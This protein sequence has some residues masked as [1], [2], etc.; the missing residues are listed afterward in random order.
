MTIIKRSLIYLLFL[1]I[2]ILI[3]LSFKKLNLFNNTDA[4][5]TR[6]MLS[7]LVQGEFTVIVLILTMSLIVVQLV[8]QSYSIR[9]IDLFRE[10]P[11]FWALILVYGFAIF[12]GLYVLGMIGSSNINDIEAYISGLYY[13]GIFVYVILIPY[14]WQILDLLKPYTVIK[15]LAERMNQNDLAESKEDNKI[16]KMND[17]TVPIIDIINNSLIRQDLETFEISLTTLSGHIKKTFEKENYNKEKISIRILNHITDI[18]K[19]AANQKNEPFTIIIIDH[20]VKIG[21]I[22]IRQ[23][24]D[25]SENNITNSLRFIG[26]IAVEH[27]LKDTIIIITNSIKDIGCLSSENDLNLTSEGCAHALGKIGILATVKKIE[28]WHE[29]LYRE[30]VTYFS[31]GMIY[32]IINALNTISQN[33]IKQNL[34]HATG[35]AIISLSEIAKC[36]IMLKQERM[37]NVNIHNIIIVLEDIGKELIKKVDTNKEF[38]EIL[39]FLIKHIQAIGVYAIIYKYD[40]VIEY[41]KDLFE[42]FGEIATNKKLNYVNVQLNKSIVILGDKYKEFGYKNLSMIEDEF[43]IT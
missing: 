1:I 20:I 16:K 15:M 23:K 26:E 31:P 3:Y 43:Y 22:M 42:I 4:D 14:T 34:V 13:I 7:T 27:K 18:G 30:D 10:F 37:N 2:T 32:R 36:T 25:K 28:I 19:M 35:T 33:F 5:S 21:K 11:D 39:I 24:L 41:I 8:T 9:I 6:Y 38:E 12:A 40:S 29:E 17:P